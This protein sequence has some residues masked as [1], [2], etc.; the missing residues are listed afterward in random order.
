MNIKNVDKFLFKLGED[1][2]DVI[3]RI[4]KINDTIRER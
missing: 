1:K 2:L 4:K 3:N